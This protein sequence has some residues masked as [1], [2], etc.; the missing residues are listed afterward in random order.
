MPT[1]YRVNSLSSLEMMQ[2]DHATESDLEREAQDLDS[3]GNAPGTPEARSCIAPPPS[4]AVWSG[5]PELGSDTDDIHFRVERP[6]VDILLPRDRRAAFETDEN[7]APIP[8][9]D[10]FY[11][12][13]ERMT[14]TSD[15]EQDTTRAILMESLKELV[16]SLSTAGGE[17]RQRCFAMAADALASCDDRVADGLNDMHA[18]IFVA[19]AD[20]AAKTDNELRELARGYFALHLVDDEAVQYLKSLE[21]ED[22]SHEEEVEVRLSLRLSL[23]EQ[24]NLPV[25]SNGM[26]YQ[27]CANVGAEAMCAARRAVQDGLND[28]KAFGAFLAEWP[29][30]RRCV[31][32]R[33]ADTVR[34]LTEIHM[35]EGGRL[36]DATESGR[37][38]SQEYQEAYDTLRAKCTRAAQRVV[39]KGMQEII[40]RLVA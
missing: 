17:L 1:I 34:A 5:A 21:A 28:K 26:L 31:E 30:L 4:L 20:L 15:F 8:Q 32:Q 19:T 27:V 2:F 33:S 9:V 23:K 22:G 38:T 29:P 18:V 40:E 39:D 12:W 25:Q 35:A 24:F 11:D 37:Y 14:D 3:D 13:L 10:S 6:L 16:A 36:E 7:G